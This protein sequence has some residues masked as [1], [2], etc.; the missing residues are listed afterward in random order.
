MQITNVSATPRVIAETND[1]VGPGE[2]VEI[3]DELGDSLLEQNDVWRR[4]DRP[5]TSDLKDDWV[6]YAVSQGMDRDEAE[7]R[8]KDELINE[9][10][11]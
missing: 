3:E 1:S 10:G 5:D 8:T 11:E 9:F 6:D 7:D 4:S 2:S